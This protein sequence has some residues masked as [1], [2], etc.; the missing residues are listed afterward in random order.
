MSMTCQHLDLLP[1]IRLY[2][3]TCFN[4]FIKLVTIASHIL[5]Q[6]YNTFKIHTKVRS[7]GLYRKT[8]S[9]GSFLL[10]TNG[11]FILFKLCLSSTRTKITNNNYT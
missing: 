5:G 7:R 6:Q 11:E 2:N 8:S 10:V 3:L 1:D 4:L 9:Q